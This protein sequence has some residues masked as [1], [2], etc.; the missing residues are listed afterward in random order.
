MLLLSGRAS[1]TLL[2]AAKER[3]CKLAYEV[4][5]AT[6]AMSAAATMVLLS[7]AK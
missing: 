4:A 7:A 3:T 6:T 2:P 5:R 1:V